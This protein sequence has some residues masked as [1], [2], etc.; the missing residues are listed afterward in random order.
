MKQDRIRLRD[1][2]MWVDV[3]EKTIVTTLE[4]FVAWSHSRIAF[5][6]EGRKT[7]WNQTHQRGISQLRIT[8]HCLSKKKKKKTQ[9]RM[10]PAGKA[11]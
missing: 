6:V 7:A 1:R 9:I 5:P 11:A 2:A 10:Q 4:A 3:G 8:I